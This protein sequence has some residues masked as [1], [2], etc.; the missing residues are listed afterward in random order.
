MAMSKD[1]MMVG[2]SF[3]LMELCG[4]GMMMLRGEVRLILSGGAETAGGARTTTRHQ[5]GLFCS[6]NALCLA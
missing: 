6:D 4:Q 1:A 3:G 5:P 2:E